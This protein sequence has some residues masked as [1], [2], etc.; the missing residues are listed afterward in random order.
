MVAVVD[1]LCVAS[2]IQDPYRTG[3]YVRS[4]LNSP[5]KQFIRNASTSGEGAELCAFA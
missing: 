1:N 4:R 5:K 3:A 2:Q